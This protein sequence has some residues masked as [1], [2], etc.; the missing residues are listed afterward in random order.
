MAERRMFAKTIV[1]SGAFYKLTPKAQCLY[2]HLNMVADDDG[3]LNNAFVICRSLGLSK[4]VLQELVDSRFIL[5]CGN[6]I[7]CIK[8]WKINNTIAKDRYKPSVYQDVL[9]NLYIKE[10][11]SY[12]ECKQNGNNLASQI[13]VDKIRED[14]SKEEDIQM[15]NARYLE[16]GVP[17]VIIDNAISYYN[18][19]HLG[20]LSKELGDRCYLK[21]VDVLLNNDICDK[22]AYIYRMVENEQNGK[23]QA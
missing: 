6:D 20:D 23:V 19:Y 15:Y 11:K 13:R 8:H 9:Q 18:R 12:T 22:D 5:D 21:I 3:L 16:S 17:A 2:L 1:E 14:K 4:N 10:N 7:V